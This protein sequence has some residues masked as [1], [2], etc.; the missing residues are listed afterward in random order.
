MGKVSESWARSSFSAKGRAREG[1]LE[2]LREIW[3]QGC[4][5]AFGLGLSPR[6]QAQSSDTT[7][8]EALEHTVAGGLKDVHL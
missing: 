2:G 5:G 7:P 6:P 1:P 3:R 4:W 8:S